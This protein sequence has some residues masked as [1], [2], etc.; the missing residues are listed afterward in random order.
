MS[1]SYS[2]N[3]FF[4][5]QTNWSY[6]DLKKWIENGCDL[7]EGKK[8]VSLRCS[9][10]KLT[11]LPSEI[12]KLVNLKWLRCYN[13]KLSEIPKFISKMKNLVY[14]DFSFNN[15]DSFEN[16]V[17]MPSLTH[18]L[19]TGNKLTTIPNNVTWL[20]Q[21]KVLYCGQNDIT[22]FPSELCQLINL[23]RL[24]YD[25]HKIIMPL[26][27][28][29]FVSKRPHGLI[30]IENHNIYYSP[31]HHA[32]FTKNFH[33]IQ[34]NSPY[35]LTNYTINPVFDDDVLLD[36]SKKILT[37]YIKIERKHD[38]LGLTFKEFL[39]NVIH[40]VSKDEKYYDFI[41][42]LNKK[43]EPSRYPSFNNQ[44]MMLL[45]CLD[46]LYGFKREISDDND[47]ESTQSNKKTKK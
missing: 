29:R 44:F 10:C 25:E 9:S 46:E 40:V 14:L 4:D 7:D 43:I 23:Q 30:N 32:C 34:N 5:G 35:D 28:M 22:V 16:I 11:E 12:E 13:N 41:K 19:V 39:L 20:T 33:Y 1:Q 8:A 47:D 31:L 26:N 15:V 27:V 17:D 2:E 42:I 18:L 24:Q 6:G 37:R 36:S 21:L 3:V 38:I 45:R